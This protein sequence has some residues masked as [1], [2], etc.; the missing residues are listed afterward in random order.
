MSSF[1]AA[2][3]DARGGRHSTF[4]VFSLSEEVVGEGHDEALRERLRVLS[5]LHE[6][7]EVLRDD[8]AGAEPLLERIASLL[9]AAFRYPS[10]AAA[11]VGYGPIQQATPR[12]RETPWTLRSDF[13][14]RE[15]GTGRL[16]VVYL[17]ERPPANEGPFLAAE[18]RLL[19]TLA[20][21]LR[22]ALHRREMEMEVHRGREELAV[23]LRSVREERD[24]IN[25]LLDL[26]NAISS[27]LDSKALLRVISH[28]LREALPLEVASISLW[29]EGAGDL[30]R[31]ALFHPGG[32]D[33]STLEEGSVIPPGWPS[34]LVFRSGQSARFSLDDDLSEGVRRLAETLGLRSGL[35]VPLQ[36]PRQRLGVLLVGSLDAPALGDEDLRLLEQIARQLA[37]AI[38]N[39][40]H[41]ERAERYRRE[42]A[43]Q[44]DQLQLLL[45]LAN[46]VTSELDLPTLI[47]TISQL[48]REKVT[49]HYVS[50]TLWDH[51]AEQ[52]RRHALVF[53][54]GRGLLR[55]GAL[56]QPDAPSAAVY[57]DGQTRVF[58]WRD[59]EAI[60]GPVRQIMEEEG[61]RA[62]CCVPLQTT[63]GRHGTLNVARPDDDDFPGDEVR[64]LEQ[65]GRQLAIAIENAL[66]FD[67]AERF[68]REA[69]AGRDRLRLLLDV[70]NAV[71]GHLDPHEL[72]LSVFAA[73]WRAIA[74]DYA[75]LSVVDRESGDLRL[76]FATFYDEREILEPRAALS[77]DRTPSGVAFRDRA[78]RLFH[79]HDIA[80][81]DMDVLSGLR[82]AALQEVCSVPLL[83]TRGAVGA[84]TI[85]R[86]SKN[87]FS[88]ADVDLLCEVASQVAIAVDNTVAYGE[89]AA[90]K[91]RLTEEKLY[92]EDQ[93][94]SQND[95]AGIT[96]SSEA[97]KSVLHQVRTVAPTDATVLLLGE[98]GTGKEVIARAIHDASRRRPQTFVRVNA[99]ALP[100]A[101][102]ESELFGYERGAFTGAVGSKVGRLELADR[103]T[104]F[105]DEIG[106][107]PLDTQPKLLRALQEH[108]FERLG[109]TRTQRVDVRL[110]AATNRDLEA[111]V[112]AGTFRSDLYYRLSVFPIHL[113]PL[114]ERREDIPPLV[115][116]FVRKFSREMGRS[117]TAISVPTMNRLVDW[118]WPGNIR[119]LQNV[120][121][122]AVIL[123]R[124]PAL[125][126]PASAFR[127]R[128][129]TRADPPEVGTYQDGER[130]L[131]L[132][133]L[134]ESQGVISGPKGAAARLGIK[135]TTLN[136]KMRKLG[137]VRPT[138]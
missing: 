36:T 41:F 84:L 18:R 15:G 113:P 83:T 28:L 128:T 10:I 65:I 22:T 98:T 96:G 112:E 13:T 91:D 138:F 66:H 106:D 47:G 5:A 69:A 29:D 78:P 123:S 75:S 9:P 45:D 115:W 64:L 137:I 55:D 12:F 73:V 131:I 109:S 93:L 4:E 132:R 80:G 58:R 43:Q 38:E 118:S 25:L 87:P 111:M 30:R 71:V 56:V 126:V 23:A 46:A 61:L 88:Q 60:G 11:R 134:R 33:L 129:Q 119:E 121:E 62:V 107:M 122:R 130:D 6:A 100:A 103:G 70:N 48:L 67:E 94:T 16:E 26:T 57:A 31:H 105:L 2:L 82:E 50:V 1:D 95:F 32:V 7:A 21:M 114:R 108:E 35:A 74:N 116:H 97:L 72:R 136:S 77:L 49:H 34:E 8:S 39:A 51:D 89:I 17:E 117:I 3:D 135:R 19:D 101:L 27:T 127:Q 42:A 37:V 20:E 24:R 14:T 85:G 110:I 90:L 53:A 124:G 52:L 104:L 92:L 86:T 54:A 99:A 44:R 68:R 63:R 59:I 79:A 81:F 133:A 40:L 76:E 102:V 125:G 120:I